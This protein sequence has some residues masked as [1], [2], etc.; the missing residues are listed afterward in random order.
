MVMDKREVI[1]RVA[2]AYYRDVGRGIARIDPEVMEKLGLKSGDVIEIIGKE[3]VP[4]IVWPGYPEDRGTGTIRIDGSI[5]N[6]AGIGIGDRVKIRK[7]EAKPAEKVVLAPTEPVRLMGGENYLL[8]LLEGRPV[9]RGQKIR[10]EVFGHVLTFVIVSTKPSGVVIVNRGTLIELKEKPVEEIRRHVPSVTYED[11][12]GLKRELRLVREMIELPLKHPELFQ[13]LGI[14]PPKGVLLYGPPGTGKTLIAKAVANEVDAHFIPVSGPEIMSK[15]YGESEQRLREI[16]EEAKENSP[17]IIF[18]DE[19]DAIAPKREEVTGEVERRVV[20]QLLA[21]MDGLEARGNVIVIG[22]TNRPD[23]VD[24][25]LRR[26]GRFDREIEIGVPDREGRKEILQI[27]TRGMPIEPDYNREDVLKVLRRMKE[28]GKDV[29]EFIKKVEGAISGEMVRILKEDESIFNDVR[30]RLIDLMLEDL[31]DLTVGFVGAD[32]AALAKEAAM[33]ALRKRIE[34][35]EIDVEAEEIPEEVLERLKVTKEDFLEALKNIEPSAMREVL[36]EI[37]KVTWD[38]VGGLENAKQELREAIEWPLK[39]PDLFRA[40][41]IKPPKGILLYGPPGTGKT[42]IAKAVA[43]ESNANFIS[44]KGP[45]LLSKWVGESITG[46]EIVLAKVNGKLKVLSAEELYNAWM[47]GEEIEIPCIRFESDEI[48]FSKLER[49][50]RHVRSTPIY[51]IRTKTG[52]SVK[53]TADH[54]IFTIR[55]GEIMPIKTSELKKGDCVLIPQYLPEL[56]EDEVEGVKINDDLALL[57][58]LYI[59]EGSMNKGRVRIRTRD[60]KI[61]E[62][63]NEI[64]ERLGL[65]GKYYDDGSYHIKGLEFFEHFGV[66]AKNKRLGDVLSL[67]RDLLAKVLQ[68]YFS[69]DGSFYLKDHERSAFIEAVTTSKQLANE[70]LVALQRFGI[71]ANLKV[72]RNRCGNYEYRILIGRTEFIRIFAEEIGFIQKGKMVRINEFLMSRRWTRGKTDVPAELVNCSSYAVGVLSGRVALKLGYK[73]KALFFDKV[74]SIRKL[75]RDDEFVYDLVEV[76]EGLNFIAGGIVVHNS[77]KHVREMFRKAKQVAPSILFFD[78]IDALAPRRGL[79]V[80]THVTERVVSQLLTELDGIE[81]LKDV[82]VIAATNRPDMIDPALLRPGR[83]ERHIYIPPPDKEGRKE[84]FKIHLRGKPLAYSD[85]DV[86]RAVERLKNKLKDEKV[87]KDLERVKNL[88]DVE[89]LSDEI[90][91]IVENKVVDVVCEWLAE[92]T[93]GY[94]GADIEAI[95]REAGMLAIREKVR[96][97]M[98]KE[99]SKEIAKVIRIGR[100]HFEKAMQKIKPSLTKEDL[101]R[102]EEIMETFHRMYA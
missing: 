81:E 5:R 70:L 34:I 41:G 95:C 64:C 29:D 30:N 97:E 83:I 96:H 53:V 87:V 12:G 46:D 27:H 49:V 92:K 6:N 72:R 1:L 56:H 79:G 2:E 68:G 10:V 28:E 76:V 54:S 55:N 8:R 62:K 13:R 35:G 51:E 40:T 59:A 75:N 36:V 18:F 7:V 19:I 37:P 66:G 69:G 39:Y 61:I 32:L 85:E 88:K 11:I 26:P 45:E 67:R 102:Y 48:V 43:N 15:Y 71:V 100:R 82:F 20:A 89:A 44:V 58:G 80:D 23:A 14:D 22:A 16:F 47:N 25:A 65:D 31:A 94:T 74:S 99:E 77:E 101:R 38:D 63:L 93:E 52:R 73:V 90:R 78:E 57:I 60:E 86:K 91:R 4:A 42:L 84:I 17:S 24:P 33:H 3:T 21:L 9:K 50:A 98:T